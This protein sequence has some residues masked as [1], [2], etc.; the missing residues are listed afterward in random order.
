MIISKSKPLNVSMTKTEINYKCMKLK[1]NRNRQ[2][3]FV[4]S[5]RDR[6]QDI[7]K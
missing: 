1:V 5:I 7:N 2:I 4:L 3:D 6:S